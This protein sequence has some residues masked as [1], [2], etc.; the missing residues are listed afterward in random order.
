M[1]I[2][3]LAFCDCL[4]KYVEE[5]HVRVCAFDGNLQDLFLGFFF[6]ILLFRGRDI[7]LF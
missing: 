6:S 5:V 4:D 7:T 2:K 3:V 1:P